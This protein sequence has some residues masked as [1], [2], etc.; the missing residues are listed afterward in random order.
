MQKRQLQNEE[1]AFLHLHFYLHLYSPFL[2]FQ[3]YYE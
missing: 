3:N 2:F 1:L